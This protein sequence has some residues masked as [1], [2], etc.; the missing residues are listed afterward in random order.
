[1][2]GS[3]ALIPVCDLMNELSIICV[4]FFSFIKLSVQVC[5]YDLSYISSHACAVIILISILYSLF[6]FHTGGGGGFD[7]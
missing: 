5:Y 6:L 2:C 3:R 7:Q 4:M 1:M